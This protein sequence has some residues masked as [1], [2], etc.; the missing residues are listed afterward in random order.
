MSVTRLVYYNMV[1]RKS[2]APIP[3]W[4]PAAFTRGGKNRNTNPV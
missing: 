2:A 1:K 3:L 4:K